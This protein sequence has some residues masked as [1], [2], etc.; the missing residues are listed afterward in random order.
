M[1]T[2]RE[3]IYSLSELQER[4]RRTQRSVM[5]GDDDESP[6][7][8]FTASLPSCLVGI[9]SQ[10]HGI[11]PSIELDMDRGT[12]WVGFNSKLANLDVVK[13]RTNFIIQLDCVFYSILCRMQDGSV[14]VINELGADRVS[15]S[16]NVLWHVSTY[17]LTDFA[18]CGESIKLTDE[19]CSIRIDKNSGHRL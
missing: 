9:C 15:S 11:R 4:L 17:L 6:I 2:I 18:D 13:C 1:D 10:G 3:N 16:G 14:I 5:L 7:E 12:A 19:N 8:Y